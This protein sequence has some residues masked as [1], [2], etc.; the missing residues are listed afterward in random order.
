MK[1]LMVLALLI[2]HGMAHA[3]RWD[4]HV[5][6][7]DTP[8]GHHHFA[9]R[10]AGTGERELKSEARFDVKVLFINAYRYVHDATERW[11]G[12]CLSALN[13]MTND[14]GR[15]TSVNAIQR[16]GRMSIDVAGKQESA[17]GCVMSFAYW[18]MDILGQKQL[19]NPQT[20]KLEAVT[21]TSL[22]DD[23]VTVRGVNVT[24]RRYRINGP[25]HPIELWYGADRQWLALQSTV[26][27]G[28][29]LRYQLK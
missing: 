6:L 25:K 22:G 29:R 26:D 16:D 20:G 4:F 27:G 18:S 9:L 28:R 15:Q 21:I 23:N 1:S 17:E 24:A 3:Q 10:D 13:A 12:N 19:L 5:F 2:A 8:I 14:N 7:D 11:R